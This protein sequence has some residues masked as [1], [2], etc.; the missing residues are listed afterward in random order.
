M[1][2]LKKHYEKII[3]SVVLLGLA[4]AAALLPIMVSKER[5]ALQELEQGI[6]A[7]PPKQLKPVD[8]S[9]NEAVL[10]RLQK[11]ATLKLAGDHNLFNPVQWQRRPDGT[12]F[13]I[14]AGSDIGPG[15]L[16]IVNVKPLFLKIEFEGP[17]G[18]AENLQY[19]FKIVREASARAAQRVPTTR[20]VPAVGSKN[21]IFMLKEMR[22]KENPVEFVLEMVE[23]KE[24]VTVSRE[25]PFSQVA[26][27]LVDLKYDPEKLS[28]IGKRVGDSLVFTG[29]TN[30]IVAITETN[31]TVRATS[32]DKRTTVTYKPAP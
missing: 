26:G 11:P 23:D 22:P 30:K 13:P 32:N 7:T 31:V 15:A 18:T 8:L 4:V 21:D 20:S 25:K 3:L 27:F 24:Q 6:I 14:R 2:L 28:F 5:S 9:T 29:D 12:I 10:A 19:R 16:K 17:T 1:E